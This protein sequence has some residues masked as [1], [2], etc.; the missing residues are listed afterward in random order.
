MGNPD[1]SDQWVLHSGGR[2]FGPFAADELRRYFTSGMVKASDCVSG[3]GL[4]AWVSAG[5]AAAALGVD[6][7]GVAPGSGAAPV[8]GTASVSP[9]AMPIP[10]SASVSARPTTVPAPTLAFHD[11]QTPESNGLVVL[12][13]VALLAVQFFLVP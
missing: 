6:A 13:L 9:V 4:D 1:A 3:P 5:L 2:E 7:P 8:V 12:W 10:A 11:E